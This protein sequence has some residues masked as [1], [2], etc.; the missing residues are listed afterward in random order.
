MLAHLRPG[1]TTATSGVNPPSEGS[2]WSIS[3]C[4]HVERAFKVGVQLF[5]GIQQSSLL[6][7]RD[8]SSVTNGMMIARILIT[9]EVRL[10]VDIP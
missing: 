7:R 3:V 6:R 10:S 2:Y 1:R 9:F 8:R 4:W 5:V